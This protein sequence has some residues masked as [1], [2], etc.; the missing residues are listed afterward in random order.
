MCGAR[1]D[2]VGRGSKKARL[3]GGVER[4]IGKGL[5]GDCGGG[6][7]LMGGL[8]LLVYGFGL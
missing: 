3:A 7:G 1:E 5:L 6:R 4:E 2:F 8:G